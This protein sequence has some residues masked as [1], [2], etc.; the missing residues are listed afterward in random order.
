MSRLQI[1]M[2]MTGGLIR[3]MNP[4]GVVRH[5]GNNGHPLVPLG[6]PCGNRWVFSP[7]S[8]MR[9][10]PLGEKRKLL[11]ALAGDSAIGRFSGRRVLGISRNAPYRSG[12]RMSERILQFSVFE[13]RRCSPVLWPL[14]VMIASIGRVSQENAKTSI[15]CGT[16]EDDPPRRSC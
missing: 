12:S 1:Q 8:E 14:T 2:P 5:R 10:A 3:R 13:E 7:I 11:N 15:S 16:K 4:T 9:T 6:P